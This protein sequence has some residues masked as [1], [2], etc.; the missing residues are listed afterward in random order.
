MGLT[1]AP[2]DEIVVLH[3]ERTGKE[4][5]EAAD[6]GRDLTLY[7]RLLDQGALAVGDTRFLGAG[8]PAEELMAGLVALEARGLVL[9]HFDV[10]QPEKSQ[11]QHSAASLYWF[12]SSKDLAQNVR[13]YPLLANYPDGLREAMALHLAR[14]YLGSENPP[15]ANA[16]Q[17]TRG[18]QFAPDLLLPTVHKP[19][20]GAGDFL[21]E[22]VLLIDYVGPPG[23]FRSL[24]LKEVEQSGVGDSLFKGKL[25]IIDVGMLGAQGTPTSTQRPMTEGEMDANVIQSILDRRFLVPQS[26]VAGILGIFLL[27]MVGGLL[28][29][30]L[31]PLL[32]LVFLLLFVGG[33]L[34]YATALHRSGTMPDTLFGPVALLGTFVSTAVY[35]YM[36]EERGRRRE[37]A[38]KKRIRETFG[39]Y[40]AQPV[41][42]KLLQ[43]PSAVAL[44]GKRQE[45]TVFF[46]DIRGY[47]TFSEQTAPEDIVS[48]LNTYLTAATKAIVAHEGTVD[49][50]IGDAIMAYFNAP[51][52]QED[53]TLRAIKAALEMQESLSS[54]SQGPGPSYGIGIHTGVAV[55]GNIGAPELMSYTA[56]GDAVNVAARLQSAAGPGQTL[57]SEG[58]FD[59]VRGR[60][61]VE[62]LGSLDVK[63]RS[64]PVSVYRVKGI[65]TG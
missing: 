30:R 46:A 36:G 7:K 5:Y 26:I 64:T 9:R 29:A 51:L 11:V 61:E 34:G 15:Q 22:Y 48:L 2:R 53:H 8:T 17:T 25:V 62:A 44:G 43:D 47:T 55:V 10:R 54:A 65:R 13:F 24:S 3:D 45:L 37:E 59:H 31:R 39:H 4:V 58:A 49:K 21:G 35:R 6:V 42:E 27:A 33:Y 38:E 40:L 60:V 23:T 57:I 1:R 28:F 18:Y 52:P 32:A 20:K 19:S 56:I 50:Y 12:D 63:G 16:L 41:V 14:A